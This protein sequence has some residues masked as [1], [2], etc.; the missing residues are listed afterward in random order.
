[1]KPFFRIIL[2]L[3]LL[4]G[5]APA[6]KAQELQSTVTIN[7]SQIEG[8][9]Q[10]FNTLQK[11]LQEFINTQPW[12]TL[13][14]QVNEKIRCNFQFIVNTY[15]DDLFSC[16]LQV[17]ATRPVF[18]ASYTSPL[19]NFM[20]K[21]VNFTYTMSDPIQYTN[22]TFESNLVAVVSYY[23][24]IIIGLY[25]DTYG[26]YQG[27]ALFNQAESIVNI[28]QSSTNENDK[29]GWIAFDNDKNRYALIS[30]LTD[31]T[32]KPLREY[33]YNYHRKGL[34]IMNASP[35]N[36][37]AVIASGLSTLLAMKKEH[38]GAVLNQV[39]MD[40]KSDELVNIFTKHGTTKEKKEAYETLI[41]INPSASN[42][43]SVLKD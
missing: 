8:N 24:N 4:A 41:Y 2:S 1:M 16:T 10:M 37:R 29:K 17:M 32:F 23:S 36:G 12:T 43:Y 18:N 3:M 33:Y 38:Q 21:E 9:D 13:K 7:H 25:L 14:F 28:M 20:D 35:D 5:M 31:V 6:L 40:T 39:F 34:D 19:I 15:S 30:N 22:N 26:L 27:T 11:D 42:T